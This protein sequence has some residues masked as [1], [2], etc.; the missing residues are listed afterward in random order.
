M[1]TDSSTVH[2]V[3]MSRTTRSTVPGANSSGSRSA[4]S[5]TDTAQFSGRPSKKSAMLPAA[6]SANSSLS[7]NE[8]TRPS[9]PT[10]RSRAI[11]RAPEPTPAS[12]T[13]APG[14]MSP[15]VTMRPESFG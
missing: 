6:I 14:R 7:S 11:D 8:W 15:R 5:P 10:A 4:R 2:G 12:T 3:S 13:V 9:G 1:L